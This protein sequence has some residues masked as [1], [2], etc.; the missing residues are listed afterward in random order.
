MMMWASGYLGAP[1][2]TGGTLLSWNKAHHPY[3]PLEHG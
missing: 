1:V 3:V 2:R